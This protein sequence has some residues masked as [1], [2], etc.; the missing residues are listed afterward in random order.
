MFFKK[1][2]S[3]FGLVE[4]LLLQKLAALHELLHIILLELRSVKNFQEYVDLN[5]TK[6]LL[7]CFILI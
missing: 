6:F 2:L 4:N 5:F 1:F 3:I 7:F